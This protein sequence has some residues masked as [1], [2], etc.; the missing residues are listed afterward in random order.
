MSPSRSE[1]VRFRQPEELILKDSLTTGTND[2]LQNHPIK[3]RNPRVASCHSDFAFGFP[4][5]PRSPRR[6][7]RLR[8]RRIACA[9]QV[10]EPL[11]VS[12]LQRD[13]E[14][15]RGGLTIRRFRSAY[16]FRLRGFNSNNSGLQHPFILGYRPFIDKV[17]FLI[18]VDLAPLETGLS[19]KAVW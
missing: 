10:A 7:E 2:L 17:D 16:A 6:P 12:T 3:L 19:D 4:S 15:P 5:S 14:T 13:C 8:F 11:R 18:N 9:S 1:R